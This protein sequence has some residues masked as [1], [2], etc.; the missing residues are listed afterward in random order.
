MKKFLAILVLF[1]SMAYTASAQFT[2]SRFGTGRNNDNTGRVTTYNF[3]TSYDAAGNDTISVTPNAWQTNIIP[4][5]AITDSVNIKLNLTRCYLGDNLRVM[6]TKGSGS[7]A[8]RFPSAYFINDATA[9][10]YTV[11]ANKTAVFEFIF[12]GTK[13]MM[14]GKTIQP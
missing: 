13:F 8:I 6:V 1:V 11:A 10:R 3:V 12:T 4:S 5:S 14:S 2:T 7:G 9:N